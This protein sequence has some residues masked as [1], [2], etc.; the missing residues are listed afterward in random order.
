MSVR[1]GFASRQNQCRS[2][3]FLSK[4]PANLGGCQGFCP[5]IICSEF[6]GRTAEARGG[7]S[8]WLPIMLPLGTDFGRFPPEF[9]TV[10][11]SGFR[12]GPRGVAN[13]ARLDRPEPPRCGPLG[14][15]P[16]PGLSG[17]PS[18]FFVQRL[19]RR[20]CIGDFRRRK[21][22][23]SLLL[24]S[25]GSHTAERRRR[26]M[27]GIAVAARRLVSIRRPVRRPVAI[28]LPA[29]GSHPG[30]GGS[31]GLRIIAGQRP[32][33]LSADTHPAR[34]GRLPSPFYR[35]SSTPAGGVGWRFPR[36]EDGAVAVRIPGPRQSA[37][38]AGGNFRCPSA[39]GRHHPGGADDRWGG[40]GPSSFLG[41]GIEPG[42]GR[43]A[44][45]HDL[46]KL[47]LCSFSLVPRNF[48]FSFVCAR[49]RRG[50]ASP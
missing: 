24:A 28:F 30:G 45:G 21:W 35:A 47:G 27:P 18:L 12:G 11:T 31:A 49:I 42:P 5:S 17:C 20:R 10:R 39:L 13:R 43:G 40:G 33:T 19:Q 23:P 36:A 7:R 3:N 41:G 25:R 14:H 26:V 15:K 2:G 44:P 37:D 16:H 29:V 1:R 38:A 46:K 8:C 9:R 48:V 4:T 6:T 34:F 32:R 50:L 22:F